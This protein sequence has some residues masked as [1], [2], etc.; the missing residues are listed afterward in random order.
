MPRHRKGARLYLRERA[1]RDPIYVI[2]DGS[3]EIGT[4]CGRDRSRDA[5]Q[6]LAS[7]IVSKYTPPE[8]DGENVKLSDILIAD[9]MTAYLPEHAPHTASSAWIGHSTKPILE[10]W[11]TKTLADVKGQACRD[12]VDWRTRQFVG[13]TTKPRNDGTMPEP[14]TVSS[15]TARHELTTLR[16]AIGHWH[17]E[18]GPLPTLPAVTLP[19]PPAPRDRW[20]LRTEP[21]RLVRATRQTR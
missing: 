19:P 13:N 18:H 14:R 1:G 6:M 3:R 8:G 15:S 17:R 7:Y 21:A 4:G 9:V 20:L 2:L 12:Y 10:W 11:G 16:A 5:E